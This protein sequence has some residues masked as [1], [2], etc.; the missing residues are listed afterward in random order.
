MLRKSSSIDYLRGK[1]ALA[2]KASLSSLNKRRS[3]S[4]IF[5]RARSRSRVK[6]MACGVSVVQDSIM[7]GYLKKKSPKAVLGRHVWE[8]RYFVLLQS[9]LMYYK[10]QADALVGTEKCLGTIPCKNVKNVSRI[11]RS[12]N[13]VKFRFN[14]NLTG[15]SNRAFEFYIEDHMMG[16]KWLGILRRVMLNRNEENKDEDEMDLDNNPEKQSWKANV[17]KNLKKYR[18]QGV[19][20]E[21]MSM[22]INVGRFR[23]FSWISSPRASSDEKSNNEHKSLIN[24]LVS[25]PSS[26]FMSP[27]LGPLSPA[28]SVETSTSFQEIAENADYVEVSQENVQ[29]VSDG[30]KDALNFDELKLEKDECKAIVKTM[31]KKRINKGMTVRFLGLH[32]KDFYFVE[33]GCFEQKIFNEETGETDIKRFNSGDCFGELSLIQDEVALD[34]VVALEDSFCW[35]IDRQTFKKLTIELQERKYRRYEAFLR[36]TQVIGKMLDEKTFPKMSEVV[37]LRTFEENE[38]II[39][40]GDSSD[41][42]YILHTGKCKVI[43]DEIKV[44]QYEKP[45]D[46]FGERSFLTGEDRA[47][48]VRA[49][50]QVKVLELSK[51][52]FESLMG[53]QQHIRRVMMKRVNSYSN[54]KGQLPPKLETLNQ[55]MSIEEVDEEN[56]P[57]KK[58][59]NADKIGTTIKENDEKNNVLRAKESDEKKES[60]AIMKENI[61][62]KEHGKEDSIIVAKENGKEKNNA[63]ISEKVKKKES[64]GKEDE[65]KDSVTKDNKEK[66]SVTKV[67]KEKDSITKENKEKDSITK[68]DKKKDSIKKEDKEKDSVIKENEKKDSAPGTTVKN[69]SKSLPIKNTKAINNSL[70]KE[71]NANSSNVDVIGTLSKE[72][73]AKTSDTSKRISQTEKKKIPELDI[74]ANAQPKLAK[75]RKIPAFRPTDYKVVGTLGRGSFGVVQLVLDEKS[76]KTYALKGIS[77]AN[78]VKHDQVGFVM[79]ERKTMAIVDHPFLVRLHATASD[80]NFVYFLLEPC[81]GGE[82]FCLLNDEERISVKQSQFYAASITLAFEYMHS[83]NILYRDLKPENILLDKEGYIKITDFGFAKQTS[84]RT[85]TFCGT[86][87]YVAPEIVKNSGHGVGVD[88]WC[89][90]I[91]IF[92]MLSGETPFYTELGP[93]AMYKRIISNDPIIYPVYFTK[94]SKDILEGLLAKKPNRRLGVTIGGA[95]NVKKHKW[96]EGFDFE[97]LIERRLKAPFIKPVKNNQ[98]LTNFEED[99]DDD[100]DDYDEYDEPKHTWDNVF[101]RN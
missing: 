88:W 1:A 60:V 94:D 90:G 17:G 93:N 21:K 51:D 40:Q 13:S 95:D 53:K 57:M 54:L 50:S 10:K 9:G 39:T 27:K 82:L 16:Q 91:L 28:V 2:R 80:Q 84:K 97:A 79:N 65:E 61:K 69:V 72:K 29:R 11:Y 24:N 43:K 3:S 46:Y 15:N 8:E 25:T 67:D 34:T 30:I 89:L 98:D 33:T 55:N 52:D 42:F 64:V 4:Q 73:N 70:E 86:P 100:D 66:D 96:F 37:E 78:L 74:R 23:S 18:R 36:S 26:C 41:K 76:Q 62:E 75:E 44:H 85:Y 56:S 22:I 48:T 63:V 20:G 99:S 38:D 45:G 81:L 47:A 49:V 92:E 58:K 14:I 83:Q 31:W 71:N 5:T 68:E 59:K 6:S 32:C 12:N 101:Y 87:D 35:I 7:E 19:H 77:K